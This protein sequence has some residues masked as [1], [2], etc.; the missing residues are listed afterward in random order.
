MREAKIRKELEAQR[1]N[2]YAELYQ[3]CGKISIARFDALCR[4]IHSLTIKIHSFRGG[5]Y[6]K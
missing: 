5:L 3:M 6:G 4:K 1:T 2:L